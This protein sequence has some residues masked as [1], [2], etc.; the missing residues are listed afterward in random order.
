MKATTKRTTVV[1]VFH[2]RAEAERAV[3]ELKHAGFSAND[4]SVIT[5]GKEGE[6]TAVATGAAAGAATGAGVAALASLGMTFGV[7]PVIGPILAVG[8]LAA[9]LLSAAG[10]AAA[11]GLVGALAGLGVAE[12]EAPY[13]EGEVKAGRTLV[14]VKADG[15]YDEAWTIL[16]RYHAYNHENLPTAARTGTATTAEERSM[17]LHEEELHARKQPV[18]AGE[19]RVR[20]EVVT[21]HKTLDVPVQREEVIVER[22]P[23]G[24][25]PAPGATIRAGEEI[26]I[27][28]HEEHV[29]VEKTPVVKEE[30]TVGKRKVQE[31]EHVSGDV[32]KEELRVEKKGDVDVHSKGTGKKGR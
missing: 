4:I 15:R 26:R 11:G 25:K 20:K 7:I 24:G 2:D 27:P 18:E 19:V 13:Y 6:G 9:A 17:K 3:A 10:G 21:E 1:G 8:P 12:S 31:T 23:V 22:H 30:V 14:T 28:V 16:H 5:K 29:R 32:R